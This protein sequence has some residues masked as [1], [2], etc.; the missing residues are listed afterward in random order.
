MSET[1][2]TPERSI[3]AV[4]FISSDE[5]R[6]R[7]GWRLLIQIFLYLLLG[8]VVFVTASFLGF[9]PGSGP[10]ALLLEQVLNIIVYTGSVY[11]ARRWLDKKSFKSLGLKLDQQAPVDVL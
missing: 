8:I 3:L 5:P 6:L 2:P 11:I 9:D 1:Q 10:S 7:A 4:I